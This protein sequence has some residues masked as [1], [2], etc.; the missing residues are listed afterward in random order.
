MNRQN[1]PNFIR[2][3]NAPRISAGVMT[4]NMH[5][6]IMNRLCG[7]EPLGS[8]PTSFRNRYVA[9]LPKNPPLVA[10]NAML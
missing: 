6:K 8:P 1:P 2:S 7:I 10:P 9:G 5:W 3:A 4:A